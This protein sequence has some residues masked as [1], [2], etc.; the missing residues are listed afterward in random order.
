MGG[1]AN[2]KSEGSEKESL[3][4]S[5]LFVNKDTKGADEDSKECSFVDLI[6]APEV[7]LLSTEVNAVKEASMKAGR[8]TKKK[9]DSGVVSVFDVARGR[10]L[11]GKPKKVAEIF[12]QN[13]EIGSGGPSTW[14]E[15]VSSVPSVHSVAQTQSDQVSNK[16]YSRW[17]LKK[18]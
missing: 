18:K 8:R 9:E 13:L 12:T 4:K 15:P 16:P 2:G 5:T 7:D 17:A 3:N 1:V 6:T 14:D 11:G 10:G